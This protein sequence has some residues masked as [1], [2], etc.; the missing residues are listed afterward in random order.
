M[1]PFA[2]E[3][4]KYS[5]ELYKFTR[6]ITG[7]TSS[8][9]YYF[10]GNIAL[11]AGLDNNNKMSIRTD[12]AIAVGSVISNIKDSDNNLI[13]DDTSWQINNI[14]PVLNAF[15]TIEGY[16]LRAVPFQGTL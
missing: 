5:G 14:Q 6:E 12:E 4:H 10:V 9:K 13:L 2:F 8:L 3:R 1:K 16:R 11:T 15:N 7:D